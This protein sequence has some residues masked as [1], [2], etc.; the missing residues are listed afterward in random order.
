[1]ELPSAAH[2]LVFVSLGPE[3][4]RR[5]STPTSYA[6]PALALAELAQRGRVD[7]VDKRVVARDRSRTGVTLLDDMLERIAAEPKQHKADRLLRKLRS[8]ADLH[9]LRELEEMGLVRSSKERWMA[10]VPTTRY[11]VRDREALRTATLPLNEQ[12]LKGRP[13]DERTVLV[14]LGL[15]IARLEKQVLGADYKLARQ[16]AHQAAERGTISPVTA[17]VAKA[18]LKLRQS[19][20]AAAAS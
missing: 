10:L 20:E 19:M 11:P 18:G 16:N 14:G 9:V 6:V 2:A 1:M 7:L 3:G 17:A 8:G 13:A 15:E 12:L 5:S 4:N